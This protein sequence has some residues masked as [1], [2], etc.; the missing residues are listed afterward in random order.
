MYWS[1]S[2]TDTGAIGLRLRPGNLRRK[3]FTRSNSCLLDLGRSRSE[4]KH[5]PWHEQEFAGTGASMTASRRLPSLTSPPT[6]TTV[7][8]TATIAR[9]TAATITWG[10]R[11]SLI[12][13]QRAAIQLRAIEFID[14]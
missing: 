5:L 6:T 9:T 12:H 3:I 10:H 7:T 11:A 1:G 8:T 2:D 4:I 14:G 13:C